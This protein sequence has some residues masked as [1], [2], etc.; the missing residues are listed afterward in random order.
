MNRLDAQEFKVQQRHETAEE[1]FT[2]FT[3]LLLAYKENFAYFDTTASQP[4]ETFFTNEA[5]YDCGGPMR[6][7][8]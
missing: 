2:L 3:Q 4:F 8:L 1:C 6:D 7:T 5:S